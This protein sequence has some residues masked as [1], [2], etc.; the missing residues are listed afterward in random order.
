MS[1]RRLRVQT[2][3]PFVRSQ[4]GSET[5]GTG[6]A[7]SGSRGIVTR[8]V[9]CPF[10]HEKRTWCSP[11]LSPNVKFTRAS[12]EVVGGWDEGDNSITCEDAHE[13]HVN[14]TCSLLAHGIDRCPASCN[15]HTVSDFD[16]E[17]FGLHSVGTCI[18][19]CSNLP[20]GS[21]R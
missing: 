10:P 20:D 8:H 16:G 18:Q 5:G 1:I 21:S 11:N 12:D 17:S 19:F 6:A 9:S 2:C 15:V 4:G 3:P 7:E 13:L 14:D